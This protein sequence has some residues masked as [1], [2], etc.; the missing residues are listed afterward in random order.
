VRILAIIA[1]FCLS[2]P[3]RAQVPFFTAGATAY[4]A[5]VST[6][7][8]STDTTTITPNFNTTLS[9]DHKYVTMGAQ[10]VNS[11]LP[12]VQSFNLTIPVG[13]TFV[14][15]PATPTGGVPAAGST[16]PS[17]TAAISVLDKPGMTLVA[18]LR[19]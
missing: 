2:S 16:T 8:G 10:A 3:A 12:V 15:M 14:G 18:R 17:A 11:G 9:A 19:D 1:I 5:Q 6:I 4:S 13:G 7:S